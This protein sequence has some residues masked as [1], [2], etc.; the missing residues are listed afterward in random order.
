MTPRRRAQR[1][2]ADDAA[3]PPAPIPTD[4]GLEGRLRAAG[5]GASE[6]ALRYVDLIGLRNGPGGQLPLRWASRELIF[7]DGAPPADLVAACAELAGA[8]TQQL[9]SP[10]RVVIRRAGDDAELFVPL[11]R[12][13]IAAAIDREAARRPQV[14]GVLAASAQR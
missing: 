6:A 12:A 8:T 14:A 5:E 2:G 9:A 3:C 1:F 4:E 7:G 10:D 13:A 11:P